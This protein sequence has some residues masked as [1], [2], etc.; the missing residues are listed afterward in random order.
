MQP[1]CCYGTLAKGDWEVDIKGRT[2]LVLGSLVLTQ[3]NIPIDL[4]RRF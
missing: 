2:K 1:F 3:K 4:G